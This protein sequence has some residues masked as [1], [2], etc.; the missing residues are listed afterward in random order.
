MKVNVV[1]QALEKENL[2]D[3]IGPDDFLMYTALSY[4]QFLTDSS[5]SG[6]SNSNYL[7]IC[8]KRKVNN[9]IEYKGQFIRVQANLGF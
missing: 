6:P 1:F 7:M 5:F 2:R 3:L 4:A 8:V 9:C